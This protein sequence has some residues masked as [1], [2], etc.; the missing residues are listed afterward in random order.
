M[1]RM[2]NARNATE[3]LPSTRT[4][5]ILLFC[6]AVGI[7]LLAIAATFKG[8]DKVLYWEDV[9]IGRNL[10]RGNGYSLDTEWRTRMVYGNLVQDIE[11]K[12]QDPVIGGARPTTLKQPVFP[13]LIAAV[14]YVFGSGNFLALFLVHSV[15]AGLTAVT[16]FLTFRSHSTL[17]GLVFSLGFAFYPPFIYSCVQFLCL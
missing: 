15:I 14:F 3:F 9:S 2:M 16:F 5:V 1:R 12:I 13:F 8:N 6:L 17:I 4:I 11:K 7:R 10:V